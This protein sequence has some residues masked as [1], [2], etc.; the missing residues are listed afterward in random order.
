MKPIVARILGAAVILGV[1]AFCPQAAELGFYVGGSYGNGSKTIDKASYDQ[2]AL[3]IFN[4]VGFVPGGN[5]GDNVSSIDKD[6]PGYG[7]VAGYRLNTHLAVEGGYMDL[8]KFRY[9]VRSQGGF[10]NA[11]DPTTLDPGVLFLSANSNTAGFALSALGILPLN[12]RW[13]LYARAGV[14]FA[15]NE[16][17]LFLTDGNVSVPDTGNGSS[18]DL[19]AGAGAGFTFAEIYTLRAEYQRVFDAGDDTVGEGDQ[20]LATVG[21]TVRF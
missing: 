6:N 18:T 3:G 16:I 12:Y 20:D 1:P 9:Q 17:T 19:L 4:S 14:L 5:V 15:S 13:E 10:I 21:V 11:D 2:F 7:F 8:G